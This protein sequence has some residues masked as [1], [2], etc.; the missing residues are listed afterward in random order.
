MHT[1]QSRKCWV[2]IRRHRLVLYDK[3]R[4]L[5]YQVS[6][7]LLLFDETT[8][9]HYIKDADSEFR[10]ASAASAKPTQCQRDVVRILLLLLLLMCRVACI[11]GYF[12]FFTEEQ[13]FPFFLLARRK[14]TGELVN[15]ADVSTFPKMCGFHSNA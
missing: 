12:L 9:H 11:R 15:K 14:N 3:N 5:Y 10:S 1:Y 6:E 13:K 8:H 2:P 7:S 4:L